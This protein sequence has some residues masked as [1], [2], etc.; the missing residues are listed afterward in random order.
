MARTAAGLHK[1]LQ[2]IPELR[3]EFW[4]RVRV[5]GAGDNLNMELERA[6]RVA[7]FLEFGELLCRDALDRDESCG[8]HFRSEHQD[9]EGEAVRDDERFLNASVWEFAG[10]HQPPVKHVEPLVY[11]ELH[12]AK[13]SYK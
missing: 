6:G 1:A 12:L 4:Q 11:E 2:L 5:P 3:A 10:D 13:R 9:A 8:G 7:D